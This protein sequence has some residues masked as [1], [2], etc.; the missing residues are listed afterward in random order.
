MGR[1]PPGYG[2]ISSR[3]GGEAQ[4]SGNP[5]STYVS[6][7]STRKTGT[8]YTGDSHAVNFAW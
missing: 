6:S 5:I 4:I 2:A 8:F 7:A 1:R 3:R